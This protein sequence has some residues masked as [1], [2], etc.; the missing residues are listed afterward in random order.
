MPLLR[1]SLLAL[2]V[3]LCLVL[4]SCGGNDAPPPPPTAYDQQGVTG[5]DV[6][7]SDSLDAANVDFSTCTFFIVTPPQ[8]GS[9]SLDPDT[10][11][12]TYFPDNG[13]VGD[14]NFLWQVNDQFG[15]SNVA[16]YEIGV[17]E[18]AAFHTIHLERAPIAI[19]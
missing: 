3:P 9:Y 18:P 14:D 1:S 5:V 17:G 10:G 6:S 4:W 11:D 13:Y 8:F 15:D 2:A 16:D 19:R 12:F 7:L